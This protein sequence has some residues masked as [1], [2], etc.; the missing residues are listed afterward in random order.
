MFKTVVFLILGF[1]LVTFLVLMVKPVL[2]AASQYPRISLLLIVSLIL[3]IAEAVREGKVTT[4]LI[5]HGMSVMNI[6]K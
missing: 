3:T 2:T 1:L 5:P 6:P 4:L